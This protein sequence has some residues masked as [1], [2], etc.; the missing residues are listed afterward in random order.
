MKYFISL[1]VIAVIGFFVYNF[2]DTDGKDANRKA[3]S[4]EHVLENSDDY[5]GQV[6][7]VKG[8]IKDK[9]AV[10]GLGGYIIEDGGYEILILSNKGMPKLGD[11]Y[12]VAGK[13][14]QTYE[15]RN[16]DY[17]VMF[18]KYRKKN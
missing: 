9:I 2:L 17:S 7:R 14:K 8:V 3:Y 11:K 13:F 5:D 4:I 18:E 1:I 10:L 12:V 16:K 15:F 6:I